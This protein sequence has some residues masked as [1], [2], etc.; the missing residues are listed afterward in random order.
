M[1]VG[2]AED[3]QDAVGPDRG[4]VRPWHGHGVFCKTNFLT[5]DT[6]VIQ[7]QSFQLVNQLAKSSAFALLQID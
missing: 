2:A 6:S 3:I 5:L 7:H 4:C 1:P